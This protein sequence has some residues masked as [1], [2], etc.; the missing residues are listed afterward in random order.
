MNNIGP[1]PAKNAP[2]DGNSPVDIEAIIEQI[3]G[4][5]GGTTSDTD[6]RK[7]LMEVAPKYENARIKTYVPILL[8]REVLRRL[9]GGLAHPQGAKAA[10]PKNAASAREETAE[11]AAN[12]A[13]PELLPAR[14]S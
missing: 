6:I 9:Q 3:W 5:L 13:G 7:A 10:E 8:R 12:Y 14:S 11:L 4:D 2:V 1:R